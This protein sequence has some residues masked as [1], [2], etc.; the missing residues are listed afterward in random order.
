MRLLRGR[1]GTDRAGCL[2]QV[3]TFPILSAREPSGV[4]GIST[5]FRAIAREILAEN[6]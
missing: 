1:A 4:K 2:W 5:E 3:A 6:P